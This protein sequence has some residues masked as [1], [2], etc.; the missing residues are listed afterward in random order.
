MELI[1]PRYV[2]TAHTVHMS[3]RTSTYCNLCCPSVCGAQIVGASHQ[4]LEGYG[5][6]SRQGLR[7]FSEIN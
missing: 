6:D 5:F 7:S 4:Q 2:E 3:P 1:N